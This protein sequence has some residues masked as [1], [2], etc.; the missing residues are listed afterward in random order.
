MTEEYCRVD[1]KFRAVGDS[2][3]CRLHG[4]RLVNEEMRDKQDRWNDMIDASVNTWKT[5]T[6]EQRKER[7]RL[8]NWREKSKKLSAMMAG[9]IYGTVVSA[10]TPFWLMVIYAIMAI[11]IVGILWDMFDNKLS[12]RLG[13]DG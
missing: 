5:L 2:G 7:T 9:A 3:L 8:I 11:V 10:E 13:L 1:G 4:G 12:K 6:G